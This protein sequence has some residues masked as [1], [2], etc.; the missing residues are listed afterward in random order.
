MAQ[1]GPM[2]S[3]AIPEPRKT[4][5]HATYQRAADPTSLNTSAPS[6][7]RIPQRPTPPAPRNPPS[8]II[9]S[10]GAS[11]MATWP[12]RSSRGKSCVRENTTI[13]PSRTAK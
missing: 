7:A 8:G 5:T 12:T 11:R 4:T 9:D 6:G 13:A 1:I 2:I 3:P 10:V